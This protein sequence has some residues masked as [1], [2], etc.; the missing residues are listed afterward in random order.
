[1]LGNE[2][3]LVE[4]SVRKE[5]DP[6]FVVARVEFSSAPLEEG[7]ADLDPTSTGDLMATTELVQSAVPPPAL[8]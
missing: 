2:R 3:H 4:L 5:R 7:A 6:D 8:N 1:M